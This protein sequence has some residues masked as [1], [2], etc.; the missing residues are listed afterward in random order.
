MIAVKMIIVHVYDTELEKSMYSTDSTCATDFDLCLLGNCGL[1]A[2]E[3]GLSVDE[4]HVLKPR[5]MF[6]CPK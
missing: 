2:C 5:H 4:H 6:Y 3:Y 1:K